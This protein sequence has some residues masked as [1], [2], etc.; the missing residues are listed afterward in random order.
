MTSPLPALL[1]VIYPNAAHSQ[2]AAAQQ[3]RL[4]DKGLVRGLAA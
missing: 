4:P 2:L 3:I 1:S